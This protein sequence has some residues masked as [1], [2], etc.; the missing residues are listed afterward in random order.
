MSNFSC[1]VEIASGNGFSS[2][3]LGKMSLQEQAALNLVLGGGA[4]ITGKPIEDQNI[5][6]MTFGINIIVLGQD[7]GVTPSGSHIHS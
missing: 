2:M 1:Q 3:I 4:G 7:F 6:T 5:E